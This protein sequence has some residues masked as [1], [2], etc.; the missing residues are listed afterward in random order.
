M[1]IYLFLLI[2][3]CSWGC[4]S[5]GP[6]STNSDRLVVVSYPLVVESDKVASIVGSGF[7][8]TVKLY[9]RG[10][11]LKPDTITAT[12]IVFHAPWPRGAYPIL[13]TNG[14]DSVRPG[15]LT[16]TRTDAQSASFLEGWFSAPLMRFE[17][18]EQ[19]T[20]DE[21]DRTA[22]IHLANDSIIAGN[23]EE[24][25]YGGLFI[26]SRRSIQ[27]FFSRRFLRHT[28]SGGP[29]KGPKQAK[30]W[31]TL[32]APDLRLHM[33]GDTV[34]GTAQ[35]NHS[36]SFT[37]KTEIEGEVSTSTIFARQTSAVIVKFVRVR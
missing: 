1:K 4:V 34:V 37:T 27:N 12:E 3:V 13:I 8:S 29:G 23:A 30:S 15:D 10:I 6:T 14:S 2:A 36:A 35:G 9:L 33:E 28:V 7:D 16:V 31:Y 17:Y 18:K 26:D 11:E 20:H 19:F 25:D 22:W 5:N 21:S 32:S 24:R